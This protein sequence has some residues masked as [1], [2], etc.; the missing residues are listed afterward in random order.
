MD[1][2]VLR[3]CAMCSGKKIILTG[4]GTAGH[5]LPNIT[6][7][8][9]LQEL[10]FDVYYV[11]SHGG[12]EQGLVEFS[13]IPYFGISSGKLRRYFDLRNFT[14]IFRIMKGVWDSNKILRRIKPDIIFSKGGFVVVPLIF[15]AKL[16]GIKV[17]IHESDLTPG[18]AN[19]LVEPIANKVL[20]SFPE[21]LKYVPKKKSILTGIPVRADLASANKED[22][23]RFLEFLA[24]GNPIMLV[25]GGS[26]GSAAI[27]AC[28]RGVLPRLLEQFR[29]V[30]LCGRGNRSGIELDGY[31]EYEMLNRDLSNVLKAADIV[32][33]RAGANTL[34]EILALKKPNLLIPLTLGQSRG[35]QIINAESFRQRGFSVILDEEF[36]SE[37]FLDEVSKL[38]I[39]RDKYVEAMGK[40]E[41]GDAA[42]EIVGAIL[43]TLNSSA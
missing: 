26:Q 25:M 36:L 18:L 34:F 29:V 41:L 20:V 40:V 32:V 4:G 7:L 15:A 14:D 28:V 38:Y 30:H 39:S 35:D 17:V 13:G 33:S 27:N 9:Y 2:D 8:P 42:K 16:R 5:V 31:K 43:D 22:G 23:L 12:I 11:G 37:R 24:N 6:L 10:G 3:G 1:L 21:T 19:R